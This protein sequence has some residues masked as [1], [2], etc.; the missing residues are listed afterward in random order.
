MHKIDSKF[1]IIDQTMVSEYKIKLKVKKFVVKIVK[2]MIQTVSCTDL[3][4][5]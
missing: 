2:S 5:K 1:W 4:G 3:I